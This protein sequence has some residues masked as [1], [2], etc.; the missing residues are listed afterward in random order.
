MYKERQHGSQRNFLLKLRYG[1]TEDDFNGMLQEQGG[2]C[3]ICLAA[4]ATHVDHCHDT[5]RVRGLLCFNCN[6]ALG[7]FEDDP[8]VVG[9]A[10]EYVLGLGDRGD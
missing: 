5:N 4:P 3:V 7:R 10:L 9:R 6:A 2:L 1:I 8:A